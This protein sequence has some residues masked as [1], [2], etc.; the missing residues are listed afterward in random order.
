M[1]DAVTRRTKIRP[2]INT[3]E[4]LRA[5]LKKGLLVLNIVLH[6]R[7]QFSYKPQ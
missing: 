3:P 6:Y 4:F 2:P 1:M 5:N 7:A